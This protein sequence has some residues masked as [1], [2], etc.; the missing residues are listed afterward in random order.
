[1]AFILYNSPFKSFWTKHC[2]Q[3]KL[4]PTRNYNIYLSLIM[5]TCGQ[6]C[7]VGWK[8]NILSIDTT[9]A[10]KLYEIS[11]LFCKKNDMHSSNIGL[12]SY[13]WNEF[14]WVALGFGWIELS[15]VEFDLVELVWIKLSWFSWICLSWVGLVW[16]ELC[17][18]GLRWDELSWD[19]LG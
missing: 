6:K 17:W 2:F 12:I 13:C 11:I 14:C 18:I 1:M 3:K 4:K 19:E 10:P 15:W 8:K 9:S 16:I 5:P 7:L